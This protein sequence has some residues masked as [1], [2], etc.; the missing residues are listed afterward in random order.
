[1][2][3]TI[4]ELTIEEFA[5][6]VEMLRLEKGVTFLKIDENFNKRGNITYI[7]NN[8]LINIEDDVVTCDDEYHIILS[9]KYVLLTFLKKCLISIHKVINK[10]ITYIELKFTDG[11]VKIEII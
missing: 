1:M 3:N 2:E 10:G 7:V 6:E 4:I 11:Y 5:E 8:L 9:N